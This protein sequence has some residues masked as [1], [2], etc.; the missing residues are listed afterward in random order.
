MVLC[1]DQLGYIVNSLLKQRGYQIPKDV[2]IFSFDN[3]QL[4][5]MA[6]PRISSMDID[7]SLY[8]KKGFELLLWRIN[9]PDEPI[10]E[11][12]FMP[13]LVEGQ[14]VGMNQ[15]KIIDLG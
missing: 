10:R 5:Q 2:S 3:G 9:N 13:T 14:S 11:I 7:L 15:N 12:L 1:N 4:S 8:G 6:S